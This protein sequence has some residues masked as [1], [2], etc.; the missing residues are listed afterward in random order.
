MNNPIIITG[1]YTAAYKATDGNNW[2]VSDTIFTAKSGTYDPT[3][4]MQNGTIAFN[5]STYFV[6]AIY[7]TVD[8]IEGWEPDT[9]HIF[10]GGTTV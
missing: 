1:T 4:G 3:K 10:Y 5:S 2:I 9:F 7:T 8:M 6:P